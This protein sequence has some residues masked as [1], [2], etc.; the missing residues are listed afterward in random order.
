MIKKK[1]RFSFF[2]CEDAA[3]A[4]QTSFSMLHEVHTHGRKLGFLLSVFTKRGSF[5][6]LLE[7]AKLFLAMRQHALTDPPSPWPKCLGGSLAYF[8]VQ[9]SGST[10]PIALAHFGH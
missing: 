6:Q 7:K 3:A 1:M 5:C 10:Y 4:C 9:A 2:P 8:K